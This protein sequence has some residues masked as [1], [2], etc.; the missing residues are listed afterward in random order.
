MKNITLVLVFVLLAGAVF[1]I[2]YADARH[3]YHYKRHLTH[4]PTPTPTS[5]ATPAST[6]TPTPSQSPTLTPT[7]T[8]TST[9]TPTATPTPTPTFTS[10]PITTPT[11]IPSPT[12]TPSSGCT[13]VCTVSTGSGADYQTTGTH[14]EVV[15]N[16]AIVNVAGYST[17]A[18]KGIV[19]LNSGI[20]KD[21]DMIYHKPNVIL[22]GDGAANT[23]LQ[24]Q[25]GVP[26][27]EGTAVIYIGPDV[28]GAAV[29]NLTI[30]GNRDN[31]G[32]STPWDYKWSGIIADGDGYTLK[33]VNIKGT[34]NDGIKST[35][36]SGLNTISNVSI[37]RVGHSCAYLITS[38]GFNINSYS[39]DDNGNSGLRLDNVQDVYANNV[40][41]THTDNWAVQIWQAD[42]HTFTKNVTIE[43]FTFERPKKGQINGIYLN[44]INHVDYAWHISNITFRN[45]LVD[46]NWQSVGGPTVDNGIPPGGVIVENADNIVFDNVGIYNSVGDGLVAV[47]DPTVQNTPSHIA[48]RKSAIVNYTGRN[49]N[50]TG[51]I[52]WNFV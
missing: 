39:C 5:T 15:I 23:V 9:A 35:G 6:P 45:G 19:H 31:I 26:D 29:Q 43:N 16:Q 47:N 13:N 24:L 8:P 44:T 10:A 37:S 2:P 34:T 48:F 14:D 21:L 46:N 28:P 41:V 11:P 33:N 18:K 27:I 40:S 25:R 42:G 17:P 32:L 1:L 49:I 36:V 52:V 22:E 38:S 30:D 4:T 51:D 7:P 20:Y 50:S 3:Q 12:P